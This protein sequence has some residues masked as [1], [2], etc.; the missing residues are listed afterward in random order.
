MNSWLEAMKQWTQWLMGDAPLPDGR[1]KA[2]LAGTVAAAAV[3]AVGLPAAIPSSPSANAASQRD[4]RPSE[5][6]DPT[7]VT[8]PVA[9]S[10]P[11][12]SRPVLP[13]P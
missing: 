5:G 13:H 7:P 9:S 12:C 8:A 3:V 6:T 2:V 11:P 4:T 1:S 10:A